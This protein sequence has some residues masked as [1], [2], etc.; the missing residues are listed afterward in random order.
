MSQTKPSAV[1]VG[2]GFAG[3]GCAKELA[4]HDIPVTLIDRNDYHQFQPLLY[5]VATAELATVDVARPLR[6]IFKNAPTVDFRRADVVNVDPAT[7]TVTTTDGQTF[8]IT[9][10]TPFRSSD[11]SHS[12]RDN[13]RLR[14]SSP[15]RPASPVNPSTT[16]TR[17]SWP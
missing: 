8:T 3:V 13:G 16:R 7:R 5:Q 14:T 15:T 4:K 12:R 9:T 2:G 1:I 17:A 6:A 10:A 11:R